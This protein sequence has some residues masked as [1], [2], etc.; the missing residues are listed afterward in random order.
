MIFPPITPTFF[1]DTKNVGIQRTGDCIT[2][3]DAAKERE[4][5]IVVSKF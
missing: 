5:V 4:N 2:K 3:D 1:V